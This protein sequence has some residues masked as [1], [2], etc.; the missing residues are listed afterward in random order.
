MV[1][2]EKAHKPPGS[3]APWKMPGGN[4]AFKAQ[5]RRGAGWSSVVVGV[6][7]ADVPVARISTRLAWL[8]ADRARR[9]G[10]ADRAERAARAAGADAAG[11]ERA[12]AGH[13]EQA[14]FEIG[15]VS[16]FLQ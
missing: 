6:G 11:V 8:R 16:S 12:R 14:R 15:V 10:L 3:V 1:L 2:C 13:E 4:A 9:A 7:G 5:R